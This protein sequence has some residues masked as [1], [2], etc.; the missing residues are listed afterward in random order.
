MSPL[1]KFAIRSTLAALLVGLVAVPV[2][3]QGATSGT[4]LGSVTAAED[5]TGLPGAV[6]EAVHQPTGTR[7]TSVTRADGRWTIENARVGGPYTVSVQMDGFRPAEVI[8]VTVS[9]SEAT[10]IDVQLQLATIEEELTVTA[11]IDPLINPNRTGV[12]TNVG[13]QLIEDL[14]NVERGFQDLARVS[15]YFST[16]GGGAGN[17]QTVISVAGRNNRYNNIQI[18][19]A[20][21]NDLFGLAATGVP[22]GSAE[23]QPISLDAIQEIA[24]L[25]SPYDVRQGGFSGGG[26]NAITRSGTNSL[27]GSVY[28]FTRDQDW[29]GDGPLDQELA[30]FSEDEYGFRLGGPIMSDELFYFVSAER[31][32][33]TRPSGVSADGSGGQSFIDPAAAAEFR[34]IL[35]T[36]Y[37]YDPGGLGQ[38]SEERNSDK[39]FAR[40][41][42]NLADGQALTL[43]HNYIDADNDVYRPD[44]LFYDFPDRNY[45]FLNETNST[46]AQLN[47]VFG[48][49]MFNEARISY[50]TIRDRRSGGT[51]FPAVTVEINDGRAE[52]SAGVEPFSTRNSLDQD[53]LEL[54]DDF[55]FLTGD[56]TITVGTHNEIFSFSNVFIRQA[57][58]EYSFLSLDDFRNGKAATF[59]RSFSLTGDP[60]QPSE[61]DVR[62]F[63]I[64]AGD[65]WRLNDSLTL[66]YGLRVDVPQF[67]DDP[68]Y[69]P[70]VERQFGFR[71]DEVPDGNELIS[72]RV[73][74]NYA[75]NQDSQVRGGVGIFAGRTP[76]VW[77]SNQYGNTGI[78]FQR[79]NSFI[80]DD[81]FDPDTN[82]IP[83]IPD[84]FGQY[85]DPSQFGG[86]AATNEINLTDPDFELPQV[87]RYSLGYD[88]N[89][90][91]GMNMSVEGIYSDV[92]QDIKYQNLQLVP[93]G[94]TFFDGRPLFGNRATPPGEE[95][96]SAVYLLTN[97]SDGSEWTSTI[98]LTRPFTN[99]LYLAASWLYGEAE[100]VAEG[101]SSQASS[102]WR[103]HEVQRDPNNPTVGRS[104]F[105]PGHRINLSGTYN[106][107]L[108]PTG[109]TVALFY[110]A[111]SGRPYSTT[112]ANDVN[113]D[114]QSN[115]LLYVP[116]SADEVVVQGGTW[117]DLDAYIR[118]DEGL[119]DAR[120]SIVERNASRSPWIHQLD[121]SFAVKV[122]FGRYEPEIT[123]DIF[124]LG[125][126]I[127]SDYGTVR[128]VPFG[129][130]S[131]LRYNG[132]T[133]DGKPIYQ[134]FFVEDDGSID[135]DGRF[136]ID[137]LRSRWQA[138]LGLRFSF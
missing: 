36:V 11:D 95:R 105:D 29:V 115:D 100:V 125:N 85:T 113:G 62:Q 61:F 56:H 64:Y 65:Q 7:Y 78:E 117:E 76:Y 118:A 104:D 135:F 18:D 90:P 138:K 68:S 99:G 72:P 102:N 69:N 13:Q 1:V 26:I 28:Y 46:V 87:L 30:E 74:F 75:L 59:D 66:T 123:F 129:E 60:N 116:R 131:P 101:T 114:F 45:D 111:Q 10:E 107:Q 5:G 6:V 93:T 40:L 12:T 49:D 63:G 134:L 37:G 82:F 54:H 80:D 32:E 103:F 109:N 137:D 89:L 127:D 124:N 119:R 42:W 58:G 106:F 50:Q 133:P 136:S 41:D 83:F 47:S 92:Q 44:R 79:I 35:T 57:F 33:R 70:S 86:R 39:I 55:T 128:Y 91:W 21:N 51:P 14:P 94:Q 17:E 108:G 15:P 3:G 132:M 22:G 52:L 23:T 126:L 73:G 121:F 88:T 96:Y 43:R 2:H 120:G 27:E 122:P 84:P 53:I 112:F 130:S 98:R 110:T 38:A 71:T 9:L 97:T 81:E 24:L 67:P 25:I 48:A 31:S 20:V 4:L 77:I 19:G 8:D 16:F 34:N